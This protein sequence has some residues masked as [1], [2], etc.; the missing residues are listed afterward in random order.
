M[1]Q[2]L[3]L[4][5]LL[6]ALLLLSACGET[7]SSRTT[8]LSP[9]HALLADADEVLLDDT[10]AGALA[11]PQ[12]DAFAALNAALGKKPTLEAITVVQPDEGETLKSDT[13][14]PRFLWRD[15]ADGS[16]TW[17]VHVRLA[18]SAD[19]AMQLLVLG[20]MPAEAVMDPLS[21]TRHAWTPSPSVW[22]A[23]RKL[24]G[25]APISFTFVGLAADAPES[26]LTTGAVT[27]TLSK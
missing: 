25:E 1:N 20:G 13:Q 27:V 22:A 26:P 2:P 16:D 21:A 24:A 3:A 19:A 14:A 8:A 5:V 4:V 17:L 15:P 9:A 11:Q 10:G 7:T 18:A 23:I 12:L 6:P